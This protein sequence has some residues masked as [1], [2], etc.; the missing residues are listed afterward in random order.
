MLYPKRKPYKTGFLDVGEGHALHFELY[1]NRK[2]KPVLFV[3]GGPGAGCGEKAHRFFDPKK[4]HILL[5]DQRGAGKSK[6]FASTKANT[7]SRLVEDLKKFIDFL[8]IKKV[9]LFGGSWGSC[10]SLCFAIK[11]PKQVQA[12]VLRGIFLG[13]RE[14]NEYFLSGSPRTHFP[15]VVERFLSLVPKGRNP[16]KYYQKMMHKERT[17]KKFCKEWATYELSLLRL[18]PK[19]VVLKGK[20]Y[21]SLAKLEA[22]YLLNDC[23]LPKKYIMS[24]IKK[25]KHIP[26]TIVHGRY[27]FVTI[28]QMAYVLHKAL[29][30]SK[31]HMVIGGHSSS[32]REVEAALIGAMRKLK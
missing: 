20:S 24:N 27:D 13:T 3:H 17:A 10:L 26:C 21:I 4:Y 22:H 30:K 29:P 18:R 1:G 5:I 14:E 28:P 25:I 31:L 7:T 16:A 2:G 32:D 19:K 9:I 8:G 23:F 12:M 6:P 15:E 11:Y